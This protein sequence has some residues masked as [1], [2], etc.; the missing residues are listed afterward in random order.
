MFGPFYST[1]FL[2]LESGNVIGLRMMKM[3]SGASG[4]HDEA[5]LMVVEKMH[6][7]FEASVSLLAGGTASSVID[8][9]REHVAANAERLSHLS[10]TGHDWGPAIGGLQVPMIEECWGQTMRCDMALVPLCA[11]NRRR[12]QTMH[13]RSVFKARA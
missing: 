13:A 9:Y 4:S 6:A 12:Q 2:A 3:M 11:M 8:R 10:F 5:H 1:M 7:M